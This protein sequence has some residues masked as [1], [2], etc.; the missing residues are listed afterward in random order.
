[1][2][3]SALFTSLM[4]HSDY[5]FRFCDHDSC[6]ATVTIRS[7]DTLSFGWG[8]SHYC[9]NRLTD[10]KNTLS[11]IGLLFAANTVEVA[12]IPHRHTGV[13]EIRGWQTPEAVSL[14]IEQLEEWID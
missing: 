3:I 9:S 11:E 12:L 7:G 14:W 10:A 8:R 4:A 5:E 6:N 13:A 2:S 1:M